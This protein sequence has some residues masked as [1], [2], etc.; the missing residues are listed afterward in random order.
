VTCSRHLEEEASE[1]IAKTLGML[2]DPDPKT[3]HSRFSGI[4]MV[5]TSLDPFKVV[6][7]IRTKILD[8]PWSIRYCHRF[9]P[10]RESTTTTIESIVTSV[11]NHVA[12]MR[13]EDSYR[14][15]VEKRG[16]DLPTKDLIEAVAGVVP[17]RVSLEEYD[18]N[19]VIE[20]LGNIAGISVLRERDILS[21]LKLKRDTPE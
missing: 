17:N 11:R 1:E 14:I 4:V 10:L 20:I 6:D 15:T 9:I 16:S 19:I 2:G 5:D 12:V 8:E 13:P 18:W 21:T 3:S 7:E